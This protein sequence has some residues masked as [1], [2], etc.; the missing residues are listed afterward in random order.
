MRTIRTHRGQ[1]GNRGPGSR[2][3]PA[4][5]VGVPL[6]WTDMTGT[7]NMVKVFTKSDGTPVMVPVT[8]MPNLNDTEEWEIWNFTMDAH[9]IHLHLVEFQVVGRQ[10]LEPT[11]ATAYHAEAAP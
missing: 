3:D 11:S 9:P 6:M 10:V 2:R 4:A 1:S 5:Y 7:S 8:E